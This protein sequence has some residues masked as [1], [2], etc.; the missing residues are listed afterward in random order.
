MT[1]LESRATSDSNQADAF[2]KE[3]G[4]NIYINPLLFRFF[5]AHP[6]LNGK[7]ANELAVSDV[8]LSKNDGKYT[9]TSFLFAIEME[10]SRIKNKKYELTF[11]YKIG[12]DEPLPLFAKGKGIATF[13]LKEEK[14][15][16]LKAD[17]RLSL[18]SN[19][20]LLGAITKKI[21]KI[22]EV[23]FSV[24]ME[25]AVRDAEKLARFFDGSAGEILDIVTDENSDFTRLELRCLKKNFKNMK[26]R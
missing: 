7:L 12:I 21:P 24:K 11:N 17:I 16:R 18:T 8:A 13:F 5:L 6:G 4:M 1:L 9:F 3:E 25:K 15:D 23:I 20:G 2:I 22:L 19:G 14:E 10:K 26:K